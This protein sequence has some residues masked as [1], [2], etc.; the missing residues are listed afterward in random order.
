MTTITKANLGAAVLRSETLTIFGQASQADLHSPSFFST[1]RKN[2]KGTTGREILGFS[3]LNHHCIWQYLSITL[4]FFGDECSDECQRCFK[5]FW[6][7][8]THTS[9]KI[10]WW[11]LQGCLWKMSGQICQKWNACDAPTKMELVEDSSKV[12]VIPVRSLMA[13]CMS[14]CVFCA[15]WSGHG[16]WGL[17][18]NRWFF[19]SRIWTC[20]RPGGGHSIA[21]QKSTF[22]AL[23]KPK[24]GPVSHHVAS[25]PTVQTRPDMHRFNTNPAL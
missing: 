20:S 24:K 2:S 12:W 13:I 15:Q 8:T 9:C 5:F 6:I 10:S 18:K 25:A 23:K 14:P 19:G 3:M 1:L 11:N 21:L 7:Y 17:Q 22:L 4:V 16:P